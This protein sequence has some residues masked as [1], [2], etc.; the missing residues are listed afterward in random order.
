MNGVPE[1]DKRLDGFIEF[2]YKNGF[3]P[4][5]YDSQDNEELLKNKERFN[6]FTYEESR[7]LLGYII[8]SQYWGGGIYG[9]SIKDGSLALILRRIIVH[10]EKQD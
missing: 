10:M 4:S 7:K 3:V 1:R 5:D 8:R 2:S 9:R 6:S